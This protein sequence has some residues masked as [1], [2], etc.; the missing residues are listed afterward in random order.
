M[1]GGVCVGRN[2]RVEIKEWVTRRQRA[3]RF[4]HV[5]CMPV[6]DRMLPGTAR[7]V[8]C[9]GQRGLCFARDSEGML[10]S[11]WSHL[12]LPPLTHLT[13]VCVLLC[14]GRTRNGT[15]AATAKRSGKRASV[16]AVE[17]E[18]GAA[19]RPR[20]GSRG[21]RRRGVWRAGS[22]YCQARVPGWCGWWEDFECMQVLG[23]R[24]LAG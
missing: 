3:S 1:L 13:P 21:Y 24:L 18:A 11:A 22:C 17:A 12:L 2:W 8:F 7:A 20:G 14:A 23:A 15:M 10:A 5:P 16:A 9:P 4:N 19:P 6:V